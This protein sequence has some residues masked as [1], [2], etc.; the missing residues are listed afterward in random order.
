[1]ARQFTVS[2]KINGAMD[3]SLQAALNAAANAMRRLGQSASS[4][5]AAANAS[6]AGL[7]GMAASLNQ[8]QTAAQRYKQLQDALKQTSL[9]F[10]RS[11]A[12]VQTARSKYEQDAAAVE[13]LK[14]K[15]TELRTAQQQLAMTKAGSNATLKQLRQDL[16][17]LKRAY[18]EAKR[19]G[20][21]VKMSSLDA[22]IKSTQ[23]ALSAQQAQVR[24]AAQAYKELSTQ[25]KQTKADLQA[26][27]TAANKSGQDL[28]SARS[29]A[30]RLKQSFQ[31]Q[32]AA[33]NQLK[34]SLSAAGFNVSSFAAS[35]ER[36]A[37]DINRVNAALQRQ[38][39]LAAARLNSQTA[40]QDLGMSAAGFMGS[41]YSAQQA[42]SPFTSAV[43]G[44]MEF[45]HAMSRVKALT[46]TS[47]IMAGDLATVEKEMA[48]LEGQARE[49]GATTQ[50]TMTQAAE[51][52]G[53]LGMA[54]WKTQQIYGTMP[55]LLS[56]AAGAGTDL[57]RTADI[58]SDNMTA[59][60]VP[61]EQAGHFMDV[62]AYALTNSNVTLESLGETMKYAAPVA[63]AFGA[64][65]EDTAAMT[66]M[67]GNAGIKG[68]MAGTALRMGL[69]RLSGPPKKASKAMAELGIS[70]S[71][72]TAMALESEAELARLGVQYDKNA[73]PMEK[74]GNI[75]TQLSTKMQG[76]SREE[77]LASIGAIFGVNAASGWVNI[78][79]QGPEVFNRYLNALKNSDGYAKQFAHTMND[80]TRGAMIALESA[81]DAVQKNIGGALLPAVRAAAQAFT[82]LA[83]SA[84][85]FI[86][87]HPGIIQ[88]VAGIV[89]AFSSLLV[90]AAGVKLAFAGFTF[91]TSSF[92]LATSA[93]TAFR[94]GLAG[95]AVEAT[96][97]QAVFAVMGLRLAS[98]RTAM[99]G[100]FAAGG[101]ATTGGWATM[102]TAIST[103]AA[104]AATAIR[105]FF[106]SLTLGSAASGAM[107]TLSSIGTAIAGVARAAM[108]FA[109]SPI[110]VALMA[111]ALAG[112]YVYQNWDKVSAVFS[113]IASI[114]GGA[115]A[116]AIR[117]VV[118]SFAA[119]SSNGTF[120]ALC[121]SASK[122][123]SIVGGV[124]VKAFAVFLTV[125]ASAIAVVLQ[126]IGDVVKT[127]AELGGGI[128]NA[129]GKATQ[130]DFSGAVEALGNTATRTLN[131]I[132]TLGS[133]VFD[134]VE[135]GAKN[136]QQT[137]DAL[138]MP[139]MPTQEVRARHAVQFDESG[140]AHSAPAAQPAQ[141]P[142]DTSATQAALDQV[143]AS[144]QNAATNMDGVNQAADAMGKFPSAVQPAV[145][146]MAQAGTSA[147]TFG[148][149]TQTAATSAQTFG[150]NA[151]A[152][153]TNVQALGASSQGA[154]GGITALGAAAQGACAGTSALGNA[155]GGA[156]N[157]V[158]GLG[159][160]AQAACSQLAAAGANAAA[161]VSAAASAGGKPVA[162]NY[163]GGIYKKGAFLTTFA[164]KSPEAAIPLDGSK[165]ATELWRRAGEM[166]GILPK[167]TSPT[168]EPTITSP[169][170][171][172]NI[173]LPDGKQIYSGSRQLPSRDETR[174]RQLPEIFTASLKLPERI[175]RSSQPK[176]PKI[177][178]P[179]ASNSTSIIEKIFS[180]TTVESIF[181]KFTSTN[182]GGLIELITEK[183]FGTPTAP[184]P[185]RTQIQI[186]M[187]PTNFPVATPPFA[188]VGNNSATFGNIFSTNVDQ[189]RQRSPYQS[190]VNFP[191]TR[192][193]FSP[194]FTT[195]PFAPGENNS[196][197]TL[198]TIRELQTVRTVP[199]ENKS[200]SVF[201]NIFKTAGGMLFDKLASTKAGGLIGELASKIFGGTVDQTKRWGAYRTNPMPNASLFEPLENTGGIFEQLHEQILSPQPTAS[202]EAAP[203]NFT[204]NVTVNGNADEQTVKRGVEQAL[205]TVRN[206]AD[207]LRYYEHERRRVGYD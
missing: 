158:S 151:Q 195:P 31:Q 45:E 141:P 178:F 110:G 123:A 125:A 193:T 155:A 143:G 68:S 64:S 38:Q 197:T 161:Q 182:A 95:I 73:P 189:T 174:R 130:G 194:K 183:I 11:T 172:P 90:A 98:L 144:A 54:G 13:R 3:G 207:E 113:N 5:N 24:Q 67:M 82:P 112:L 199:T 6:K 188:P 136:V 120:D 21:S 16:K 66:M 99:A 41:L 198:E 121:S 100:L 177:N 108:A 133:H 89:A 147:Q 75:I 51:A 84:A 135:Q 150:T 173:K 20:D 69:L 77:K 153:G 28:N 42:M 29:N 176:L 10:S 187:P 59:M 154:T 202:Y 204:I 114:V 104:A 138:N 83:T 71:D 58:V 8:L 14:Q 9:D 196:T 44:A 186:Q 101:L 17:N 18:A 107:A 36:L 190:T 117:T 142:I 93:I 80:D 12:A 19:A 105:G 1:M 139:K 175:Q 206:F 162:A 25:L 53:Y 160:A 52:M 78:I 171:N 111:L 140:V 56:L 55:G 192:P 7:A 97:I 48:L 92:E 129:L 109:F 32:L 61:V 23:V 2:F 62:Y 166:L 159:A 34:A 132:K 33:L 164:E 26:A 35:E 168:F 91:I 145:D 179:T 22:Q 103:K 201:G 85:L 65:L 124:L 163:Q 87:A 76:L 4:V 27:T 50:F 94:M 63:A 43:A 49:L 131:N 106:A 96:G 185:A 170:F 127:I 191:T 181:E 128:M 167:T 134:G 30:E 79:E 60:Q 47:N 184:Q 152:A 156:A 122:L 86:Q 119:M 137:L 102:F 200:V 169:P 74:M 81:L 116:G 46:Q 157:A 72:A 165:R 149:N 39:Q 57:A 146:G 115:L 180:S 40:T 15:L 205:P 70:V 118:T 88:A 203:I 126:L 37:A 148:T